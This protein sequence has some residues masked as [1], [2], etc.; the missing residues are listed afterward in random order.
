MREWKGYKNGIN[1]GGWL[2]Q[3]V[4]T[5]EHYDS[6]ISKADIEKIKSW[7]LDHIRVPIDYELVEEEDGTEKSDGYK[8]ID[9]VIGW[10][11]ANGLNMILD[12]HKTAGY[13]FDLGHGESGFF[14]N[15]SLQ[16][17]FLKL[18]ERLAARYGV[19]SDM[20]AFELLNEVTDKEYCDPW[21]RIST[22]CIKR[23]RK[24]APDI[25]ILLGGYYNNSV[26]AIPD[27]ALPYDD[28][29]IYNFHCY[30]PLIFTHQGAGWI[31]T[32]DTS[33]RTSIGYTCDRLTDESIKQ[34]GYEPTAFDVIDDR[35]KPLSS[36]Y[37]DIIFGKA[38]KV[39]EERNVPLYC[40][41]YGVIDRTTPEE[42]VAWY[43]LIHA[44]F[45]KHSI[46]RAAWTYRKMDFGIV[47]ERMD[48]VRDELV[49]LL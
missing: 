32:M 5:K 10:C 26:E 4:H 8:Y 27:L 47:D 35:S 20:L 28:N 16:E 30:E 46:G 41:E 18:W 23:I 48:S 24:I 13:S 42:V 45:E 17:R 29:V 37:F 38:V 39:A 1:L 19:N 9:D 43:K 21:N 3:C 14:E 36:T 2:S 25:K 6:F 44:A 12:L 40:G 49:K 22:E 7:G 34:L 15:E 33:F 31:P 11:R